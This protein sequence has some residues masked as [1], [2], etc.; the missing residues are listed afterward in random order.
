MRYIETAANDLG[1]IDHALSMLSGVEGATLE[2]CGL[3]ANL[4][5]PQLTEYIHGLASRPQI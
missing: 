2:S 4:D 1:E 5:V 3:A